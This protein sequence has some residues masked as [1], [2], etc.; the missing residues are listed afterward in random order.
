MDADALATFNARFYALPWSYY[1]G[2]LGSLF[3]V[4]IK[5]FA[6]TEH[7]P[8]AAPEPAVTSDPE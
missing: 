7:V 5:F 6:K 3:V 8:M 1:F 4:S 2:I